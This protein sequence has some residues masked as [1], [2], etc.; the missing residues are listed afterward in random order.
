MCCL[1]LH[2][3]LYSALFSWA[4]SFT[5]LLVIYSLCLWYRKCN[6]FILCEKPNLIHIIH[7]YTSFV[8]AYL[9]YRQT[10]LWL[11]N[12]ILYF[13]C[14]FFFKNQKNN[15]PC[16]Y[17]S[18]SIYR[19]V[20]CV[21]SYLSSSCDLS[22]DFLFFLSQFLPSSLTLLLLSFI[23]FIHQVCVWMIRFLSFSFWILKMYSHNSRI[24]Y[25][26]LVCK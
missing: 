26:P 25:L 12:L 21:L 24:K 6:I 8:F 2:V 11:V 23:H 9:V 15:V 10:R 3:H 4:H 1:F 5:F 17:D 16:R 13:M 18:M 14:V 20:L 19:R 22:W 7:K